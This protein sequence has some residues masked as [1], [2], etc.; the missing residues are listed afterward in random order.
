MKVGPLAFILEVSEKPALTSKHWSP[1]IN[2]FTILIMCCDDL[3]QM[4]SLSKKLDLHWDN[5]IDIP[6]VLETLTTS[7]RK[8]S[9][10]RGKELCNLGT[11]ISDFVG[12]RLAAHIVF[13]VKTF[14]YD[15]LGKFKASIEQKGE[16]SLQEQYHKSSTYKHCTCTNSTRDPGAAGELKFGSLLSVCRFY[17]LEMIVCFSPFKTIVLDIV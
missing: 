7:K 10:S 2:Q 11:D 6:E 8:K 14:I 9:C 15:G 17:Y 12:I 5:C 4:P 1:P 3:R 13:S 16:P